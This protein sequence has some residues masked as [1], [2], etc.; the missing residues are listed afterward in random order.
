MMSTVHVCQ[1]E[2]SRWQFLNIPI[3][4]PLLST[5]LDPTVPGPD[6]VYFLLHRLIGDIVWMAGGAETLGQYK[7]QDDDDPWT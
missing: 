1:G 4:T 7:L 5:P 3:T 2:H 6:Y